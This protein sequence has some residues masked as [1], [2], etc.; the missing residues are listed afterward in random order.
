MRTIPIVP[1]TADPDDVAAAVGAA[2]R[3][4][5]FLVVVDHGIDQVVVDEALSQA[6]RFFA[7]PAERKRELADTGIEDRGWF[8]MGGQSLDPGSRTTCRS[9]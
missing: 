5:G 7:L 1:L 4:V 9:M 3:D 6:Q 2:C 8:P